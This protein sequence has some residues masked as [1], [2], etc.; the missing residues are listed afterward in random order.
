MIL[1]ADET[2]HATAVTRHDSAPLLIDLTT[3]EASPHSPGRSRPAHRLRST[4]IPMEVRA[5]QQW[6][7]Q[8]LVPIEAANAHAVA[9]GLQASEVLPGRGLVTVA[10]TRVLD[11]SA[12]RFYDL[13]VSLQVRRHDDRHTRR[14][15]GLFE[16]LSDHHGDLV[17]DHLLSD[18]HVASAARS[19][20]GAPARLAQLEVVP[21]G[22]RTACTVL[23]AQGHE[24]TLTI[25][26]PGPLAARNAAPPSYT[27]HNG[28]LRMTTWHLADARGGR[29]PGGATLV[30]SRHGALATFLRSLG[31]PKRALSTTALSSFSALIDAPC[32]VVPD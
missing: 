23:G 18:S 1:R 4:A 26:E 13:R 17:L 21:Q 11:G 30:L 3:G 5:A 32:V 12:G 31:L 29:R 2:A 25:A 27:C 14:S 24:L 19:V 15:F 28:L 10:F 22:G 9:S 16:S 6:S 8:W 20:W 7:A